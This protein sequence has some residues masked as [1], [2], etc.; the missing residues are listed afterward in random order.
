MKIKKS[1]NM[2]F[3]FFIISTILVSTFT[4]IMFAQTVSGERQFTLE[5]I[6]EMASKGVIITM[7]DGTF[8]IQLYPEDAPNTV[9][10]FL[11]LVESGYYDGVVFHR[12]IPGFMIQTGDPNTKNPDFDPG[13]WGTGGPGYNIKAEF[14]TLQHDRGIVSMAR[15]AHPDSGGSQFFIVHRDSNFLDGE[16]TAF[17]RLVPG[18]HS[19]VTLDSIVGLERGPGDVPV[20][21]EAARIEKAE[22]IDFTASGFGEP[23]RN[24]S[25][26][27]EERQ[28]TVYDDPQTPVHGDLDVYYNQLHEISFALP[29][30]WE[31]VSENVDQNLDLV[32]E[33]TMMEHNVQAAIKQSGFIPQVLVTAEPREPEMGI[34]EV[35]TAFFSIARGEEP[36]ILSN[37]VFEADDGRKGHVMVL[38][39]IHI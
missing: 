7:P 24:I 3:R 37:Y 6:D 13:S 11:T 2:D 10:N 14:N 34:T 29:Y 8:L 17:G 26:V 9:H 39:L 5:E 20:D 1:P 27:R 21:V 36:K 16:Y 23:D 35:N 30:R 33:P 4:G 31:V 25:V 15:S 19:L 12:I 28:L 38:S 18:T 22:V 32:I